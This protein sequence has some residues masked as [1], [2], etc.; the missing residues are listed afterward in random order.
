VHELAAV[1]QRKIA[2]QVSVIGSL[3]QAETAVSAGPECFQVALRG[4]LTKG[5]G[6]D[7]S[8]EL[9]KIAGR[10]EQV[11][12]KN[13]E[14]FFGLR[15]VFSGCLLPHD[16]VEEQGADPPFSGG[17]QNRAESDA[18]ISFADPWGHAGSPP[19]FLATVASHFCNTSA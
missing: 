13:P 16:E 6:V 10:T 2:D 5:C 11:G 14:I 15:S 4:E 7:A 8:L 1:I 9:N 19:L 12:K 18:S 3:P 17:S